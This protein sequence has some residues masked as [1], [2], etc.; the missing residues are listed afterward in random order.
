M[1]ELLNLT[2]TLTLSSPVVGDEREHVFLRL[3]GL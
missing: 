1:N 3:S 2:E